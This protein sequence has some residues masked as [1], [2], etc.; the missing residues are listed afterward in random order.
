MLLTTAPVSAVAMAL[1]HKTKVTHFFSPSAKHVA[2]VF[3]AI[4]QLYEE[5]AHTDLTLISEDGEQFCLHQVS[6][7]SERI[8]FLPG[9]AAM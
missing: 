1:V 2:G 9:A 6:S 5:Q 4:T 7:A 8:K 3:R